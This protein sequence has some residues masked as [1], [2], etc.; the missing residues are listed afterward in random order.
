MAGRIGLG[1]E[2]SSGTA[3]R[4]RQRRS[5][6]IRYKTCTYAARCRV[7][8]IRHMCMHTLAMQSGKAHTV[9]MSAEHPRFERLSFEQIEREKQASRDADDRA[10]ASGTMTP[11]DIERKNLFID[12]ARTIVHWERSGRL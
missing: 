11:R 9:D 8:I 12:P 5:S 3:E 6:Y 10:V 2:I 1:K 4:P 7:C